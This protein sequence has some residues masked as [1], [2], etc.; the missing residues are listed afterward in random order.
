MNRAT[1]STAVRS[2]RYFTRRGMA[3]SLA[4]ALA[5][6]A[7]A[8]SADYDVSGKFLYRDRPFGPGGFTGTTTDLP[9]RFA[10]VEV[11]D[12]NTNVVLESGATDA[13]GAFTIHVADNSTRDIKVRVKTAA[14][15]TPTLKMRVFVSTVN[16]SPYAVTSSTFA[17]HAPGANI[18]FTGSPVVALPGAGGDAFNVFDNAVDA[19]DFIASLRGSRPVQQLTLYWFLGPTATDGTYYL[20]ADRSIHLLGVTGA[21]ADSDGYDDAVILHEIGHYTEFT[22][23]KSENP[24]GVHTLNGTYDLRLAWSEGFST[25]FQNMVRNWRGLSRPDLYVDTSGD[26]GAGNAF[27]SYQ[28]ETPAFTSGGTVGVPGANNEV[29]VNAALWDV[30]DTPGTADGTAAVDDDNLALV[31]GALEFWQ[32]FT[33]YF[34]TAT[35]ISAEDFWD[36][37]F[38]GSHGHRPEMESAFGARGLEY[39]ADAHEPDAT[40][41]QARTIVASSPA[42]HHTIYPAGEEDWFVVGTVGGTPYGFATQSLLSGLLTHLDL[43]VNNGTTLIA[44]SGNDNSSGSSLTHT[45]AQPSVLYVRCRRVNNVHTYGSYNFIVT[46]SPVAV[47]VSEVSIAALAEGVH[48]S[49]RARQ[50]GGFVRFDV[51]RGDDAAGPW[52]VVGIGTPPAA[53]GARW[54]YTDRSVTAGRAY[55]YRIAGVENDGTRSVFGPFTATPPA[56]AR[57]AL[58]VPQ[59]NPFNPTTRLRFDVPRP[60]RVWLRVFTASGAHVRTLVAGETLAAGRHERIWDGRDDRGRALASGVYW[61]RADAGS[62]HDARRAVLVR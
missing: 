49:W 6:S 18:D 33:T 9:V 44:S 37:W 56:P 54:E 24:G 22:L 47:E 36:G 43:F 20:H 62:Q 39:F 53:G 3:V 14:L 61:V 32:A 17:N 28:V 25:F 12:A 4:A 29:S 15:N 48:L 1:G 19:F 34:P 30:V 21:N 55:A 45:P 27:I 2:S 59:P 41:G 26:P 16:P 57:L 60:G 11:L 52:T 5:C 42:E 31:N 38:A 50:D 7:G 46:G 13:T 58:A 51:E 35:T 40:P 10:D 23:A 8:A